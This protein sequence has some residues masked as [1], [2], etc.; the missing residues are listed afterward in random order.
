MCIDS[1][2]GW[3]HKQ[4]PDPSGDHLHFASTIAGTVSNITIVNNIFYQ[5]VPYRAGWWLQDPWGL[6]G[7]GKQREKPYCASTQNCGW[8]ASLVED[9]NIWF[10]T[11]PSLGTLIT[12]GAAWTDHRAFSAHSFA[13]YHLAASALPFST[14]VDLLGF[15]AYLSEVNL[16]VRASSTFR[17]RNYTKQGANSQ[18][19]D[20]LLRGLM[21]SGGGPRSATPHT[22]VRPSPSSPAIGAGLPTMWRADFDGWPVSPQLLAPDIGA[23]Q[24][25]TTHS[26]Y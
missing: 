1:G 14:T 18:T 3:S 7:T 8:G 26:G 13:E 12:L 10:Q 5:S 9:N 19:A 4:R 6:P 16:N 20:P 24:H 22:D 15:F 21:P 11:S 25:H 17:Y 23:Y 2:G